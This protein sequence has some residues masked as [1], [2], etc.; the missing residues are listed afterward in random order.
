MR[1]ICQLLILII[2][3]CSLNA[4]NCLSLGCSDSYTITTD[5][6]QPDQPSGPEWGCYYGYPRK[7]TIWQYF[8]SPSGGNYTQSFAS[9]ADLDWL[10]YDMGTGFAPLTCPISPLGWT[11]IGCDLSYNPGG[12]TGPGVESTVSTTAGHYYAVALIL[13]EPLAL[14]FTFGTPQLGGS[15][16]TAANCITLLPVKLVSFT[17]SPDGNSALLNW[18]VSDEVNVSHYLVQASSDGQ[19]FQTVGNVTANN[20]ANYRFLYQDGISVG[21]LY[22][23]LKMVDADGKSSYSV[24]VKIQDN[25]VQDQGLHIV[26]NPVV[27]GLNIIGMKN[28]GELRI[29]DLTGKTMLQQPVRS[30]T[31]S[32]DAGSLRPG[33]YILQYSDGN[34]AEVQKFLKL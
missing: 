8:Y 22:Y 5:G 2:Y 10:V 12:P 34:T 32:V 27:N 29:I 3:S 7:E 26:T 23:R 11:Q 1:K 19:N 30:Q 33:L 15:N 14:T 21:L 18:R 4:Q 24:V 31:M 25:N 6:T 28:K 16:L 17:A 9:A 13:W 20:Q